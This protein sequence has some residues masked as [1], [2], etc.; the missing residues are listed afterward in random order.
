MTR[1]YRQ[2]SL[3]WSVFACLAAMALIAD[4]LGV[5]AWAAWG[6]T[7]SNDVAAQILLPFLMFGGAF[8]IVLAPVIAVLRLQRYPGH[9]DYRQWLATTPW[10][11]SSRAPFGPWHPVLR[12]I[13]PLALL[14]VIPLGHTYLYQSLGG[15]V[16][17]SLLLQE[18]GLNLLVV[19]ALAPTVCFLLVW[20]I[21]GYLTVMAKWEWSVYVPLMVTGVLW[22][23]IN[24]VS[25]R[26]MMLLV[27]LSFAVGTVLVWKRMSLV[28]RQLPE[29]NLSGKTAGRPK[30]KRS[31]TFEMLSP[32]F[33][34]TAS[35]RVLEK[36]RPRTIA[37]GVLM[38]VW[39]TIIPWDQ[40]ALLLIPIPA[41][42]HAFFRAAMY[43]ERQDSNLGL[44][45][46]FATRRFI[47]PDF[48]RV[49]LP[50]LFMVLVGTALGLITYAGLLPIS[51]GAAIS[52]VVPTMIGLLMG[53]NYTE[54]SLTSATR[55][56]RRV[57]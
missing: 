44:L 29:T 17:A 33:E 12:D 9:G 28:L 7:L 13:I 10:Q 14:T 47:V 36:Y 8:S 52:I 30:R 55:Y 35:I 5:A 56:R 38:F 39:L 24:L 40:A 51:S 1:W 20:E 27:A 18:I 23:A 32:Q 34:P 11:A 57:R 53:P 4:L 50:S 31:E 37:I 2:N 21:G 26:M 3:R 42:V 25:I 15:A 49:W 22:H 43:C 41:A 16:R 45:A 54:W 46:R 19:V 6:R 48:D